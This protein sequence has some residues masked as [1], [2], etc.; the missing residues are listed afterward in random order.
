MGRLAGHDQ[1]QGAIVRVG[2]LAL[3]VVMTFGLG[4][5]WE[6][7]PQAEAA[8]ANQAAPA[9]TPAEERAAAMRGRIQ[10]LNPMGDDPGRAKAIAQAT[11][12]CTA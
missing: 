8:E 11:E 10:V 4:L 9:P 6:T 1:G 5:G 3:A 12:A 7:Y 2:S